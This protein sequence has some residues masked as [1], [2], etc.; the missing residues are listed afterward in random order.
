MDVLAGAAES[1]M[2]RM[3]ALRAGRCCEQVLEPRADI[4]SWSLE[5]TSALRELELEAQGP[6]LT[7]IRI[8]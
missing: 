6:C 4:T 7:R 1:G 3:L 8:R 2:C 5:N